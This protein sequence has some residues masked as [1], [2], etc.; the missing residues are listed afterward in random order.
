MNERECGA[1]TALIFGMLDTAI[2]AQRDG[3]TIVDVIARLDADTAR[4]IGVFGEGEITLRLWPC[5]TPAETDYER[6]ARNG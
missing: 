5:V 1:A 6:R 4:A 3:G 2:S